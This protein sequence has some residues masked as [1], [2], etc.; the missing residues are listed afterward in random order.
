MITENKNMMKVTSDF[1]MNYSFRRNKN[2]F[3]KYRIEMS[4]FTF[5]Y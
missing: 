2:T 3:Y 1:P 5:F 4:T